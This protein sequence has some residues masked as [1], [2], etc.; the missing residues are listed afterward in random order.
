MGK[1]EPLSRYLDGLD[2]RVWDATFSDVERIL[3]FDLPP[4]ARRLPAWWANQRKGN[5]VQARSWQDAGWETRRVDL[6]RKRVRFERQSARGENNG[7][8]ASTERRRDLLDQARRISGIADHDKVMEAALLLF[9]QREAGRR[10]IEMGGTMPGAEA[11]PRKR[12]F[13]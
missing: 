3:G 8:I 7:A 2:G 12:P 11:A 9:I 4:S 5:H 1:Y 10:L 13:G 6:S